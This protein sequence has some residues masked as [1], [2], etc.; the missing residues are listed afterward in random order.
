MSSVAVA[1]GYYGAGVTSTTRCDEGA[2]HHQDDLTPAHVAKENFQEV[3][4]SHDVDSMPI[5]S[6]EEV[7]MNNGEDGKPVW[8]TYGGVVYDVT[9]FIHN[10]PGGSEKI[11]T[12]AG[13]AIEPFW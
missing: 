4:D 9:D 10:H 11:M 13:S 6:L 1:M 2:K 3:I 8:M 12:A 7:A 5:Y